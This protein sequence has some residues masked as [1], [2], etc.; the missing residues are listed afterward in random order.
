VGGGGGDVVSSVDGR[1]VEVGA[2][3]GVTSMGRLHANERIA[4]RARI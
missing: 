3:T 4:I 1:D 2:G